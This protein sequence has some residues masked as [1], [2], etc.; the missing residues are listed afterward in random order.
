[1]SVG[2]RRFLHSLANAG[3]VALIASRPHCGAAQELWVSAS[4]AVRTKR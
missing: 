2:R 4:L 3:A 1:M